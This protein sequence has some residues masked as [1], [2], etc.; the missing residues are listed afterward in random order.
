LVGQLFQVYFE[1]HE[2]T[3]KPVPFLSGRDLIEL[4]EMEPGPEIGRILRL[5]EEGQAAGEIGSREEA[6]RFVQEQLV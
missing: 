4:F 6:L 5:I 1:K 3:V 2:E